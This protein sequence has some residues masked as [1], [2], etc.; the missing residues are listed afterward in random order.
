[1][2]LRKSS[3]VTLNIIY[4]RADYRS[5]LQEFVWSTDDHVPD[6]PRVTRFLTHWQTNI[7]AV[8]REILLG[9]DGHTPQSYTRVED[10]LNL[11]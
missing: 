6:L 9:I 2:L 8:I 11:H 3:V 7:D 1:M 5:L 4:Y 10:I